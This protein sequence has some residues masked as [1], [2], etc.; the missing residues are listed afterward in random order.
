MQIQILIHFK[1]SELTSYRMGCYL[2]FN[3]K[4]FCSSLAFVLYTYTLHCYHLAH[5]SDHHLSYNDYF[6]KYQHQ[7][8]HK[9][10]SCIITEILEAVT[11]FLTNIIEFFLL[12]MKQLAYILHQMV[13]RSIREGYITSYK[14]HDIKPLLK[15]IV[16]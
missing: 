13:Y 1:C 11:T 10:I 6:P 9:N 2:L 7:S 12:Y 4:S 16:L 14:Q 8:P 15:I 3:I 5:Y